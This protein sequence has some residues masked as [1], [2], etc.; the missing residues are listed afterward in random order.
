MEEHALLS[1]DVGCEGWQ[2]QS[3]AQRTRGERVE[4]RVPLMLTNCGNPNTSRYHGGHQ[5]SC[6]GS[7]STPHGK[8]KLRSARRFLSSKHRR[9]GCESQALD[10]GG[11]PPHAHSTQSCGVL[12]EKSTQ[13]SGGRFQHPASGQSSG[14][15]VVMNLFGLGRAK[16]AG[17]PSHPLLVLEK[18]G[19]ALTTCRPTA[20][21]VVAA[22]LQKTPRFPGKESKCGHT[23]S[24]RE[25]VRWTG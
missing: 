20:T 12:I 19:T 2:P 1:I 7:T 21:I 17:H 3:I 24:A 9:D 10:V 14:R 25:E 8:R 5:Q 23:R 4:W 22:E 15:I 6:H 16:R 13:S 18:E 11:P